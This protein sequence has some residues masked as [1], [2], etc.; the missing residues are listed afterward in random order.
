MGVPGDVSV[1]RG[2]AVA[3]ASMTHYYRATLMPN[4]NGGS[5]VALTVTGKGTISSASG[6]QTLDESPLSACPAGESQAHQ[7]CREAMQRVRA[8]LERIAER[9]R[10]AR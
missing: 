9:L 3:T 10:S 5:T 4:A 2:M 6:T 8:P 1:A 7:R